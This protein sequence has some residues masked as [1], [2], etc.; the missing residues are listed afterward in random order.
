M[1]VCCPDPLPFSLATAPSGSGSKVLLRD[2]AVAWFTDLFHVSQST[3]DE[4]CCES[5][6]R[7]L[8]QQALNCGGLAHGSGPVSHS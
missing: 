2:M 6:V 7:Q 4:L 5:R 8:L 1:N 3:F